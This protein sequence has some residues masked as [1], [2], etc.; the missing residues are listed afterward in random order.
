MPGDFGCRRLAFSMVVFGCLTDT[1][2]DT[3]ALTTTF[4]PR[5][6]SAREAIVLRSRSGHGPGSNSRAEVGQRFR[7]NASFSVT[8][9]SASGE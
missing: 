3:N 9:K 2:T 7:P 5:R 4:G 1:R 8:R 6:N